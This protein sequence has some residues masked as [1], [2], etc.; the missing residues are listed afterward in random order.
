MSRLLGELCGIVF[1]VSLIR[2][3]G[4]RVRVRGLLIG[5]CGLLIRV[6]GLLIRVRG[7]LIRACVVYKSLQGSRA[8]GDYHSLHA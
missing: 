6:R 4:F 3:R 5:V 1:E 8:A 7:L 2:V